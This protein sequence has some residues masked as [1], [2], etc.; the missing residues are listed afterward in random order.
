[1]TRKMSTTRAEW[2]E[3]FTREYLENF[4]T[5][6]AGPYGPSLIIM[7]RSLLPTPEMEDYMHNLTS[8]KHSL[9]VIVEDA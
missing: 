6:F 9:L 5:P 7:A 3:M 4:G 2:A 8:H 1:M